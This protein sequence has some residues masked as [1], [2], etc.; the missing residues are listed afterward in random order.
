M[1]MKIHN[2][3]PIYC[4]VCGD[5]IEIGNEAIRFNSHGVTYVVHADGIS[6][7]CETALIEYEFNRETFIVGEDY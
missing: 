1:E 2:H 4:D 3:H 6:K 7:D 5:E